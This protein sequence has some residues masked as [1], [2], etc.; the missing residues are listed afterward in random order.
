[1]DNS[2]RLRF[3]LRGSMPG[4]PLARVEEASSIY[5]YYQQLFD[6]RIKSGAAAGSI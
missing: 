1:M 6:V 3:I 4:C 5:A 2:Q